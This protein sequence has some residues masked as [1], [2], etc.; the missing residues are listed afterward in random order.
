MKK[1]I[2]VSVDVDIHI[3]EDKLK[4]FR[5]IYFI[6]TTD[7]IFEYIARSIITLGDIMF[8]NDIGR[9]APSHVPSNGIPTYKIRFESAKMKSY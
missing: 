4:A 2:N 5:E 8:I 7:E 6:N 3:P 9:V 1:K